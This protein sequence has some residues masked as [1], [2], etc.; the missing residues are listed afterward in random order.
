M[1]LEKFIKENR[2]QIDRVIK[3]M[4]PKVKP[5]NDAE[6]KVLILNERN[7][8][9][10][11]EAQGVKIDGEWESGYQYDSLLSRLV[12]G[13]GESNQVERSSL[14]GSRRLVI[15]PEWKEEEQINTRDSSE[16]DPESLKSVLYYDDLPRHF[17]ERAKELFPVVKKLFPGLSLKDWINGFKYDLYPEMELAKWEDEVKHYLNEIERKKVSPRI[18][19]SIW[20]RILRRMNKEKYVE[21]LSQENE[22]RG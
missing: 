3:R 14:R 6:R 20:T 5:I 11:V 21:G 18:N 15:E 2:R 9:L 12:R 16:K 7:L 13:E 4:L 10:W 19:K 1:T 8:L 17:T 22:E